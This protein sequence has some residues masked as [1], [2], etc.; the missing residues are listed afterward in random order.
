MLKVIMTVVLVF[1]VGCTSTQERKMDGLEVVSSLDEIQMIEDDATAI[2]PGI[3]YL[4]M[5]A[6]I[7]GQRNQYGIALDSYLQ[8]AKQVDDARI[9]E[10]AAKIGLYLK[11][12]SKTDEAVALWLKQDEKNLTARKIAAFSALRNADK[13]AVIE[14]L[15]K[16]L[17]GD[18][19]GFEATLLELSKVMGKEVSADFIVEVLD[20]LSQLYPQ[21]AIVYFVQAV[22]AGH[23]NTLDIALAKVNQALELQPGWNK[24]RVL[25]AQLAAQ[26]GDMAVAQESLE[27][28]LEQT[29]ENNRIRKMLAQ[30]LMKAG[31]FDKAIAIYHGMLRAQPEDGE[32]QFAL[33]LI[34]MQ[35]NKD[36]EALAY[37]KKLVNRPRW[38]ARASFYSGRIEYK[39]V[40]YDAALTWFDKVTQ[41]PYAYDASMSAVSVLL[42]QKNFVEA[43]SRIDRLVVNYPS[44]QLNIVLLKTELLVE[45]KHH[46][47]AFEVLSNAL[48]IFP[49]DRDLLYTR[50]LIAEKL[51]KLD[52]L[53]ADLKKIILNNPED[54]SALNALGYTLAD[55]TQRYE[56]A[57]TYLQ[58]A[59]A[60]KPDETVI[61]DSVGWLQFKKGNLPEALALLRKAFARLP[62]SEIA[63]HLTEILWHMGEM[64]EAKKVFSEVLK[65]SPED[66]YLLKL[67]ERIP[68]L[69]GR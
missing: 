7:A 12:T 64:E 8:A 23:L 14:H 4:L 33:A 27:S 15:G 26:K 1:L 28:I 41:G 59:I 62:E 58:K 68:Q 24:A 13:T 61:I 45:Q 57:E 20:A 6:E 40:N 38:D 25:K 56:E 53:E 31:Q 65:E 47:Q 32:S 69:I 22:L 10:R 60:L 3:L 63:V 66:E 19:A 51:D 54:S 17:Q 18:P 16:I 46:Q 50:S 55:R 67:L 44:E 11:D 30:V 52:V 21:Q 49:E 36:D 43:E 29:P 2:S 5:T 48:E 42:K 34:F 9:A 39:K 35:Q 37:L